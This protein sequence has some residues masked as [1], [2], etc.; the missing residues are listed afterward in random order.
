MVVFMDDKISIKPHCSML[1]GIAVEIA[2]C[3]VFWSGN[4]VALELGYS[5]DLE[6][7]KI[8]WGA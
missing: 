4:L 5:L 8:S 7:I 2:T 1:S 3:L 6:I